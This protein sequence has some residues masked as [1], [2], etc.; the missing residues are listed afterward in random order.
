MRTSLRN[1]IRTALRAR[2]RAVL[3]TLLLVVLT[4]GLSLGL[5]MWAYCH[6]T[7][8]AMDR[9]YTSVALVEYPGSGYPDRNAADDQARTLAEATDSG[10]IAALP[11]VERW[12][13]TDRTLAR[14]ADYQRRTGQIP[15]EKS[16]VVVAENFSPMYRDM[17]GL[18]PEEELAENCVIEVTYIDDGYTYPQAE[19]FRVSGLPDLVVPCYYQSEGEFWSWMRWGR[20]P[21]WTPASWW[22]PTTLL[23]RG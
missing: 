21:P 22:S 16:G 1:G 13:P 3:F 14:L 6:G 19:I 2:G 10:A 9:A 15:Y 5:G 23:G 11:G 18:V 7:L 20:C 8:A 17:Y 12:E 4:A